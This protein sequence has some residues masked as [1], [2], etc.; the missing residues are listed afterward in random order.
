MRDNIPLE[1][2]NNPRYTIAADGNLVITSTYH[3]NF[4]RIMI[5]TLS[6]VQLEDQERFTCTAKNDYGQQSKT[7][8]LFVD[9]LCNLIE[10]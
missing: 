10:V 6:D 3:Y 9:G 1:Q 2:L 8:N 5:R 7:M 4:Y